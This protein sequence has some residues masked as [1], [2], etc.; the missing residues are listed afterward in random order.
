VSSH[1]HAVRALERAKSKSCDPKEIS[2]H[3]ES[4]ITASGITYVQGCPLVL[5]A[6]CSVINTHFFVD[7]TEVNELLNKESDWKLGP[8][9]DGE[10]FFAFVFAESLP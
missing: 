2:K 5:S 10:E 3:A 8:L 9:N 7:H 4:L 6:D 1:P